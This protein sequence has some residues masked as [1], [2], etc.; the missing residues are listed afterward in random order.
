MFFSIICWHL[1]W[2]HIQPCPFKW[3]FFSGDFWIMFLFLTY[4]WVSFR[5]L[6]LLNACN[7]LTDSIAPFTSKKALSQ[8]CYFL[9]IFQ[10]SSKCINQNVRVTFL[11]FHFHNHNQHI[12][13]LSSL[14]SQHLSWNQPFITSKHLLTST[15]HYLFSLMWFPIRITDSILSNYSQFFLKQ[16]NRL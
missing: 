16:C 8:I 3:H 7:G 4:W 10:Y 9:D 12:H 13:Q 2:E 5:A 14:L 11:L 1:P 6:C 15:G